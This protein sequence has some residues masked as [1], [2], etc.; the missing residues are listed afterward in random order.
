MLPQPRFGPELDFVEVFYYPHDAPLSSGPT[1]LVP[2]THLSRYEGPRDAHPDGVVCADPAGSFVIHHQSILHRR[3][4][5]PPEACS[6]CFRLVILF[7]L[8]LVSELIMPEPMS[9]DMGSVRS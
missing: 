5:V 4:A 2:R 3:S 8:R 9:S 6:L 7:F 1:E